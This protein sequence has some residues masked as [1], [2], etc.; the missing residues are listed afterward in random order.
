MKIENN[1]ETSNIHISVVIP[2]YGCCECL[3]ELY[4]RLVTTLR[5]I[6][7]DFEIIFNNTGHEPIQLNFNHLGMFN[8]P[9]EIK[10]EEQKQKELPD[11]YYN[12]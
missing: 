6:T 2:V 12:G 10:R 4:K 1:N 7:E 8:V 3:N 5:L 11:E 9:T